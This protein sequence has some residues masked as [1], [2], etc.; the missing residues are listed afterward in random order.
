[1]VETELPF[2]SAAT[3][4]EIVIACDVHTDGGDFVGRDKK[5]FYQCRDEL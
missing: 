2:L 5:D 3:E 1:M 4:G